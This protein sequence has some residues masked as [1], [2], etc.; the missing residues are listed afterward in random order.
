MEVESEDQQK[1]LFTDATTGTWAGY[2][3]SRWHH[4]N[5][6]G[7]YSGE[8]LDVEEADSV[9]NA[10]ALVNALILTI[11]Y[12]IVSSLNSE[13]WDWMQVAIQDCE[14]MEWGYMQTNLITPLYVAVSASILSLIITVMYYFLRSK[15]HFAL[16]WKHRG[17][18]SVA[19]TMVATIT[20]VITILTLFAT[21]MGWYAAATNRLCYTQIINQNRYSGAYATIAAIS[22]TLLVLMV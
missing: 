10:M 14:K 20:S 3:K 6:R 12:G 9:M 19:V 16:W 8:G 2:L 15:K 1:V 7:Y 4:S 18:W 22:L 21:L 17:K 11:P 5:V 13:Y